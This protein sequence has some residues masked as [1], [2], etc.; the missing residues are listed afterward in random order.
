MSR[1]CRMEDD[2][3]LSCARCC[4]AGDAQVC[5][6]QIVGASMSWCW[7]RLQFVSF[8]R[9]RVQ[10]GVALAVRSASIDVRFMEV[11]CRTFE[12]AF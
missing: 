2:G 1:V 6:S 11:P 7:C 4:G 5:R 12:G 9:N 8:K 3:Q 10:S